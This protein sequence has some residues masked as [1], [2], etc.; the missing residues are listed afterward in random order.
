VL[1]FIRNVSKFTT[2][3]EKDLKAIVTDNLKEGKQCLKA[4]KNTI[5][6]MIRRTFV[7]RKKEIIIPLNKSLVRPHLYYCKQ[8]WKPYLRKDVNMIESV[9]IESG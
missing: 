2:K 9:Q 1:C 7:C 5:L 8:A 6:G 4:S 3:E